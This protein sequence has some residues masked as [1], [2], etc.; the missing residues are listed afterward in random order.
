M[1]GTGGGPWS[2]V[3]Q[4]TYDIVKNNA[5]NANGSIQYLG[6]EYW[7]CMSSDGWFYME[8]LTSSLVH[9]PARLTSDI[10]TFMLASTTTFDATKGTFTSGGIEYGISV[11]ADSTGGCTPYGSC[12]SK[13]AL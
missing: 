10:R 4:A 12:T 1:P 8:R 2:R 13:F 7:M 6:A 3:G 9:P 11:Q 5:L